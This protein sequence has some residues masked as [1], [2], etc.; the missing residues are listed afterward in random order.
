V[1]FRKR[2]LS[3]VEIP[4]GRQS[5]CNSQRMRTDSDWTPRAGTTALRISKLADKVRCSII[6]LA[7]GIGNYLGTNHDLAIAWRQSPRSLTTR[8]S[9]RYSYPIHRP[10]ESP[11]DVPPKSGRDELIGGEARSGSTRTKRSRLHGMDF[12]DFLVN[13]PGTFSRP[14]A[15][16]LKWRLSHPV[17]IAG[18]IGHH[19]VCMLS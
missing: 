18:T 14:H 13:P 7:F 9:Y 12:F 2:K 19:D 15:T 1:E 5:H 16:L 3:S 4:G 17:D 10:L 8:P 11:H 6:F